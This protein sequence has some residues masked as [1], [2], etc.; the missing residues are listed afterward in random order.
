MFK[1]LII[2]LLSLVFAATGMASVP[3][4]YRTVYITS[5][6]DAKYVIVSKTRVAGATM[7]V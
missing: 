6:Q 1:M 2:S 4:G 5:K 7:V 3:E